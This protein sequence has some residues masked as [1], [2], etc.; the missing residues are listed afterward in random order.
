[1]SIRT[2]ILTG[3]TIPVL[4]LVA[5][6]L[7]SAVALGRLQSAVG[8]VRAGT[9]VKMA[10]ITA[11]EMVSKLREQAELLPEAEDGP[12]AAGV[13][14]VYWDELERE[15]ALVDR[16]GPA[17]GL[18]TEAV[19][20]VGAGFASARKE[21]E[22]LTSALGAAELDFDFVFEHSLYFDEE[23]R[24]LGEALSVLG[25]AVATGME[26][27]AAA[28]ERVQRRAKWTMLVTAILGGAILLLEAAVFVRILLRPILAISQRLQS[29][30]EGEGDLTE[31]VDATRRDEIGELGRAFNTFVKRIHDIIVEVKGVASEVDE[32]AAK[33]QASSGTVAEQMGLQT[34]QIGRV[35]SVLDEVAAS[36]KKTLEGS[37]NAARRASEAGEAAAAGGVLMQTTLADIA[38]MRDEVVGSSVAIEEL[39]QRSEQIDQVTLVINEIAEQTNLLALNAAIEAARAGEHGRG[40]AVVADEV[41]KLADRTTDAT[42]EIGRSIE[43]IQK[44]TSQASLRMKAGTDRVNLSLERASEMGTSLNAIVKSAEQ[45]AAMINA[46]ASTTQ[47]QSEATD[48][49]AHNIAEIRRVADTTSQSSHEASGVASDLAGRVEQLQGLVSRFKVSAEAAKG[50]R[51]G[52]AATALVAPRKLAA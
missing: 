1:M 24:G 19:Q 30:A 29:I 14:A 42:G 43:A 50:S 25:V 7:I 17:A 52:E 21:H 12:A 35:S 45:V 27:A 18:S 16:Q 23:L 32:V 38:A 3:F 11:S 44:Q 6:A 47:E 37:L 10:Q 39:G 20:G 2:K 48:N 28:G 4:L 22:A 49:L 40:F 51:K 33:I 41:R 5:M 13:L 36:S 15:L 9:E 31:R 26:E 46:T 34:G 8:A